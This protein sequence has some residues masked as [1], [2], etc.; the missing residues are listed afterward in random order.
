MTNIDQINKAQKINIKEEE[1]HK[2]NIEKKDMYI[3]KGEANL[4]V[5]QLKQTDLENIIKIQGIISQIIQEIINIKTKLKLDNFP[6][7]RFFGDLLPLH[8]MDA[9]HR[10]C[11][12]FVLPHRS[13][14][15]S[16]THATSMS[17]GEPTIGTN[18]SGNLDFMNKRNSYLIDYQ[19]TPVYNMIFGKYSGDMTWAEPNIS[20]LKQLMRYVFENREEA[21]KVG[22]IGQKSIEK[23]L[24]SKKISQMIIDRFE[25]I[26]KGIG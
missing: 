9:L 1:A 14:G 5:N 2:I 20:H 17:Y 13:E 23:N 12:C 26:L 21:K 11:D 16:I 3:G 19:L 18:Y 22:L 24:N 8:Y 10:Q 6:A 15:F 4:E 7:I 25:T